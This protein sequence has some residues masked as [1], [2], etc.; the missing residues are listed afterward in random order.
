MCL[1]HGGPGGHGGHGGHGGLVGYGILGGHG[2]HGR[3]EFFLL[4]NNLFTDRIFCLGVKRPQ[5][6]WRS[7]TLGM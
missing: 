4:T 2:G 1:P 3:L 7:S 5:P 6:L